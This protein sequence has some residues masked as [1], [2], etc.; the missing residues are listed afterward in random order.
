MKFTKIKLEGAYIIEPEKISDE[1]GFF[2]RVWDSK[3]LNEKNLSSKITQCNI[4]FNNLKGTIRGLH[5]QK[6]PF[7]EEKIVRCTRGKIF[8]VIVDL[9]KKSNT[10][11]QYYNVELNETNQN[12]LF[13]PK[14]FA[15]G[16][17]TLEDNCE[18]FYQMSEFYNSDKA[19][20]IR[21]DDKAIN[22]KWPLQLTKISEKDQN[23][24]YL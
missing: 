10:Y 1:R 4:S 6:K 13:I 15:H 12:M 5:F 7:E 22:I 23:Y 16:F 9:R 8:D 11:L 17:Q 14:G 20:G 18:V 19:D 21:W 3:I 24:R 2:A